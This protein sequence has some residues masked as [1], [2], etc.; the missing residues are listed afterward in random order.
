MM[1]WHYLFRLAGAFLWENLTLRLAAGI[2]LVWPSSALTSLGA[3][4]WDWR[5]HVT[6]RQYVY[7]VR[8]EASYP[9]SIASLCSNVGGG[10]KWS[11]YVSS[12]N[13]G[14][15]RS[16]YHFTLWFPAVC[17]VK[18]LGLRNQDALTYV[19][20]NAFTSLTDRDMRQARSLLTS[21]MLQVWTPA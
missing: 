4:R 10:V 16:A 18:W 12:P 21:K 9:I 13:R 14:Q 3:S 20:D 17:N 2:Q 19:P 15:P 1:C 7:L 5:L 8:V 11:S 6:V